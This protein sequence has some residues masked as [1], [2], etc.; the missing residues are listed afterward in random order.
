M[1]TPAQAAPQPITGS[2]AADDCLF[3]LTPLAARFVS[4]A[5][6]ERLIQRGGRH[7]SEMI[8][9]EGAPDGRYLELF[10]ALTGRYRERLAREVVALAGHLA[11]ARPAP[12][13]I[14][15]LARAGTP[16]GAL[17]R[18]ALTQRFAVPAA[19]FSISIIRDRG[20]DEAALRYLL[21]T[22]GYAPASLV[23][24][25]AWTAKGVITGELKAA[26]AAW[27]ARGEEQLDPRLYV[28]A[29]VGGSADA[30]AT[31]DDY[32]IPSGIL[33]ATVSGLVSRTILN[34]EIGPGQFHGCVLYDD[35]AAFDQTN[36]FLDQVTAAMREAPCQPLPPS[37]RAARAAMTADCVRRWQRDLGIVDINHIKP[38]VAEATRV[39][40]RRVPERLMLRDPAH[41]DVAHLRLLAERKDIPVAVDPRMPFNA[42]AFIKTCQ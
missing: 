32:A 13:A 12:L 17:L 25:D 11:E 10:R 41:P 24:V 37:E 22:R 31:Y 18:R 6:K 3:L 20:I 27:N 35:L 15:S 40:L 33:N 2:Y 14:V 4:I 28:I 9:R 21:R 26:I 16:F 5:E 29:D 38:G 30:A 34:D 1:T 23:F 8:S 39:M 36:W 42:V 19:H 7:Y